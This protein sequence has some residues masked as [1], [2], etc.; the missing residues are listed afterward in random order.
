MTYPILGT[1]A[2]AS[3]GADPDEIFDS[4]CAGRSGLAPLRAFDRSRF[5]AQQ[6]FEID[7]RQTDG[8]DEPGR[9][10]RLL[11]EAVRQAVLDAGLSEDLAEIPVLVGTGLRELRSLELWWRDGIPFDADGLHF[12]DVLKRRFGAVDTHTFAGACSAS[13]YALALVWDMLELGEAETVVV[14]GCD[15]VTESMFGQADRVQF[16]PPSSVRPFDK[17]RQ[18][19][20]LGEG[21][22]AI[23]LSRSVPPD[24]PVRGWLRSVAVNCDAHHQTAPDAAGVES[25]ILLAQEQAGVTPA[26]ID[27]VMLHGTGTPLNDRT[28]AAVTARVFDGHGPALTG[29]KSLTGHTSGSAGLLSLIMAL[30]C[31]DQ[32]V[33]PPV[34]GLV[35]PLPEGAGLRLVAGESLLAPL[36]LAQ[37][38]S[39]GFGGVN[40][41]AIVGGAA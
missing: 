34:A 21:A 14:A 5:N 22:A 10:G 28:E 20:I 26:E 39:F 24:R 16:D 6:L 12:E 7:D 37:V 40:A 4:L 11:V 41:V 13:L 1:G 17:D 8:V 29:I 32:G 9:A 36:G 31:L 23:V 33:V 35:D 2:V 30:R 38:N 27:L 19:T 18:G 25:A 3:I 15:V